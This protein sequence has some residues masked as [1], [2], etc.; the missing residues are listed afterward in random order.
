MSKNVKV[1]FVAQYVN[2]IL[3]VTVWNVFLLQY[4]ESSE[5]LY[6]V[7]ELWF[8]MAMLAALIAAGYNDMQELNEKHN[9]K[10][11]E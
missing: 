7:F 3:W 2:I 10:K 4:P 11:T 1:H 5:L 8:L 9:G 6:S